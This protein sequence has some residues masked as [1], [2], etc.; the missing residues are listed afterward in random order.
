MLSIK[1]IN[2]LLVRPRATRWYLFLYS[3]MMLRALKVLF[4]LNILQVKFYIGELITLTLKMTTLWAELSARR[5]WVE[6]L[7]IYL[8][9]CDKI[10][11]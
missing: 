6:P 3:T 4:L 11:K 10:I 8:M 1:K 7:N 5:G 9:N 2:C